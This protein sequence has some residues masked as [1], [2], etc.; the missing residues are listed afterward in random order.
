M[1]TPHHSMM[2]SNIVGCT[3][4]KTAITST[5]H[6]HSQQQVLTRPID[7]SGTHLSASNRL[8]VASR[9]YKIAFSQMTTGASAQEK[10][11]HFAET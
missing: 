2:H 5:E 10:T 6:S 4:V 9:N 3:A 8:K 1:K 11:Y 7:L